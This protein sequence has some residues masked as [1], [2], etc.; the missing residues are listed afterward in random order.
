[1]AGRAKRKPAKTVKKRLMRKPT[2]KAAARK[3]HPKRGLPKV[4][5]IP[6][7][8]TSV[9]P[10]LCVR[11]GAAAIDF[12]KKAFGAVEKERHL[13]PD[14]KIMYARL[15]IGDTPVQLCDEM[16][17]MQY[18]VSPQ[19]LGGTTVGLHMYVRDADAAFA[20]A[21]AAGAKVS[22]PLAD[23]FWGDRFGKLTD[24]FG[25]EWSIATHKRDLS[26]KQID[27]AAKAFFAQMG[28]EHA[29]GGGQA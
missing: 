25:H 29:A 6:A 1:M 5:A 11:D 4:M 14:G 22:M 2:K 13:G 19:R 26:V 3:S 15:Q 12:Y 9:A 21:V 20:K 16:E 18:W 10:Y 27:E 8:F 7:G 23:Q 17:I 28:A 24:P